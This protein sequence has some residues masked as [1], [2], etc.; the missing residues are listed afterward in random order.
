MEI[1]A[2]EYVDFGPTLASE[3]LARE[4]KIEVSRETARQ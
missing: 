4:H 2:R 1:M 3:Y